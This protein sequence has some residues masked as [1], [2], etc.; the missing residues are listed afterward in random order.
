MAEK[1]SDAAVKAE[2]P[3]KLEATV[4]ADGV[5]KVK[6][7]QGKGFF[8]IAVE[9]KHGEANSLYLEVNGARKF[10]V[11][12]DCDTCH[13]WFKCLQEPRLPTS[14][15]IAN[16]PKTIQLPRPVDESLVQELAPL[17]DLMEK[18]EYLVFETSVNLSGPYDSEDEQS[19]FFQSEFMELWDI[20]DPKEEGLLSG[21]EHYEGQRPRIFRHEASGVMEK[22]FD[23]VIPLVPRAA[24]KDEYV[25]IYQQ[26]IQNGDRPRVL[27][28][29]MYQRGIPESVKKG[30]QKNLHS[31]M[32]GFLLD[33]HH[34]VAAYR[35]AGVP[36]KFL[37]ILSPKASKYHLLK[38]EGAKAQVRLEERLSALKP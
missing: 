20:E 31:F 28:L 15:K 5:V 38:E 27:M 8:K 3:A 25:K 22:Q 17:L 32:A 29:G 35:R 37:V 2:V 26:M 24:L 36:A 10:E 9:K 30:S 34:K 16:L 21:W 6:V 11:G 14:R 4:V 13:F 7:P 23:F 33:G 18:G 1:K 19:Y 12:N